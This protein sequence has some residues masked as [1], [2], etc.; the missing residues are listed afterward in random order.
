M[1]RDGQNKKYN[2]NKM[3]E[4]QN[5][6][7]ERESIREEQ[8]DSEDGENEQATHREIM[9]HTPTY[10]SELRTTP[11]LSDAR[12]IGKELT[13]FLDCLIQS[14]EDFPWPHL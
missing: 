12:G 10:W 2:I 1:E 7:M 13:H 8:R 4:R 3:N 14:P 6:G 9:V 5:N 11:N